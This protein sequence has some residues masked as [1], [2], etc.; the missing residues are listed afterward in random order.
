MCSVD[1]YKKALTRRFICIARENILKNVL[2]YFENAWK[3]HIKRAFLKFYM[4]RVQKAPL[5]FGKN[6]CFKNFTAQFA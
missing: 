3:M 4:H 1:A 5:K 6:G 2:V